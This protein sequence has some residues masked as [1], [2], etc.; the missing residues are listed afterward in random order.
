MKK[1]I[2]LLLLIICFFSLNPSIVFADTSFFEVSADEAAG[3][4]GA[5]YP[6]TSSNEYDNLSV[7][8]YLSKQNASGTYYNFVSAW[9]FNTSSLPDTATITSA[10]LHVVVEEI[11]TLK[12][13]NVDAEYF[14]YAG[15]VTDYVENC[16]TTAFSVAMTSF[17]DEA[18]AEITLSNPN[19][20]VSKTGDTAIRAGISG[21][22]P[23]TDTYRIQFYS[24]RY[25]S[26][27]KKALLEITY[28]IPYANK[29]NGVTP[30]KINGVTP[31]K[32]N[33][34]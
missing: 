12:T 5:S 22:T 9:K 8:T 18:T 24:T 11:S 13:R 1:I 30:I 2:I 32:I 15:N 27:A 17:T 10:K 23:G 4:S 19:T 29:I 7:V 34:I 26:G 16:G 14:T 6:P 33:G 28:S 25:S 20:Y 3:K 31:I 21:G